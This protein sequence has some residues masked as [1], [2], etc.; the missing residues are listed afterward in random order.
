M[1]GMKKSYLREKYSLKNRF[2][3]V[4]LVTIA[5]NLSLSIFVV[6]MFVHRD[7]T[8]T[9][10]FVELVSVRRLEFYFITSMMMKRKCKAHG[11]IAT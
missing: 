3:L 11:H 6:V 8:G 9:F 5:T 2:V 4:Y 1:N 7:A 10:S